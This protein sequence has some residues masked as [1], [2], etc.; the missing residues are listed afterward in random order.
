MTKSSLGV[1]AWGRAVQRERSENLNDVTLGN[2]H[3][4]IEGACLADVTKRR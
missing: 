4:V 2:P 3:S 1:R